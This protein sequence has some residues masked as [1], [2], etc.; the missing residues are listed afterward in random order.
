MLEEIR[1][2]SGQLTPVG[3]Y[4]EAWEVLKPHFWILFAISILGAIIGGAT[5]YVLLGAMICGINYC[6]LDTIEGREPKIESLF[7]GFS[8]IFPGL[9]VTAFIVIPMFVVFGVIYVP[10][11]IA[12]MM[13]ERM[14]DSEL[15][16]FLAGVFA[17][18][19]IVAIVMVCFHTLLMFS[20]H[21]IVDKKLSG[22]Q[23]MKVSA[24]G[25]WQNL[26]AVAGLW[27]VGIVVSLVGVLIFCIGTY[28]TIPIMLMAHTVAYRK[29]FPGTF[30]GDMEEAVSG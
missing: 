23:A 8:Y 10:V 21:L 4:K 17:V 28:F 25:V 3:A 27:A 11:L 14:S 24:K 15:M 6:M 9:V 12:M 19:T 5:F 7:K 30:T 22:F 1:I 20:F 29:I 16:A 26:S 2:E 18:E 13:G